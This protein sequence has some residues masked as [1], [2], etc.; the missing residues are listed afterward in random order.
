MIRI[1]DAL[2]ERGEVQA[3][4]VPKANWVWRPVGIGL[5]PG[6]AQRILDELR[7]ERGAEPA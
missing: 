7:A 6:A 1:V 2:V 5:V 4:R 3:P